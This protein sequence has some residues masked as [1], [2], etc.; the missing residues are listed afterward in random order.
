MTDPLFRSL[1]NTKVPH[2]TSSTQTE[3][4]VS[5]AIILF[6]FNFSL[7]SLSAPISTTCLLPLPVSTYPLIPSP[8]RDLTSSPAKRSLCTASAYRTIALPA[9]CSECS[10]IA[11]AI[12]R[13]SASPHSSPSRSNPTTQRFPSVSVPVLSKKTSPTSPAVSSDAIDLN[14]TPLFAAAV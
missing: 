4:L 1:V 12:P 8:G 13:T 9:G 2:F 5:K 11:R 3:L 6:D 10:S 7:L 14:R